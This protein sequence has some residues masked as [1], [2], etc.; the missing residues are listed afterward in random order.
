MEDLA[1]ELLYTSEEVE[2][3]INKRNFLMENELPN[4][5]EIIK[6]ARVSGKHFIKCD[7]CPGKSKRIFYLIVGDT[8]LIKLCPKCK[9]RMKRAFKK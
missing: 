5:I 4:G 2:V 9:R 8:S 6:I 1:Q 7:A 3:L